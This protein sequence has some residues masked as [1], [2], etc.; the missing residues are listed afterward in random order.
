MPSYL[1]LPS[2]LKRKGYKTPTEKTDTPFAQGHGAPPEQSFFSWLQSHP[3][4]ATEFHIFMSAHR[5]GVRTWLDKADLIATIAI[6]HD[7][8][9]D[10]NAAV[11]VDVG[12]G[13]GQQC[14]VRNQIHSNRLYELTHR[15]RP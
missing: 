14:E 6:A 12:G 13:L 15:F 8:S 9:G 4:N 11:F 5:T 2:C 3:Y 1:A 10:E 7:E